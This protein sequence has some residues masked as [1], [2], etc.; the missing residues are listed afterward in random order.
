M[1]QPTMD[2]QAFEQQFGLKIRHKLNL[3]STALEPAATDR[4]FEARQR[5]LAHHVD[6]VGELSLAGMGRHLF[7]M[8][9]D[10]W[11]PLAAAAALAAF[12]VC[13]DYV[14]SIQRAAELEEVDSALLADD[15][16]INAYLDR[17]FDTWLNSS[18]QP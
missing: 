9:E 4:L 11:R 2:Q 16:P 1:N 12:L 3:A 10:Y 18:A 6:S 13:G 14:T 5:A 17:G 8:G 15:L 7:G